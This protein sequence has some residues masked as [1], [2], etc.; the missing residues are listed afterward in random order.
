MHYLDSSRTLQSG[1]VH[2]HGT[3]GADL[4][5]IACPR[6]PTKVGALVYDDDEASIV[7]KMVQLSQVHRLTICVSQQRE[8]TGRRRYFR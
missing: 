6:V 3:Y 4:E 5:I 2:L 1:D 8:S 7:K